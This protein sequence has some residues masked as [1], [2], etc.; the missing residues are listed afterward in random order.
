MYLISVQ[1]FFHK[2][3]HVTKKKDIFDCKVF[4]LQRFS[5]VF[6]N[7]G[8]G[9][10]NSPPPKTNPLKKREKKCTLRIY[11]NVIKL[12]IFFFKLIRWLTKIKKKEF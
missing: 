8:P 11:I 2:N 1:D 9:T 3:M 5:K 10:P 6:S 7:E 12:Y 4:K